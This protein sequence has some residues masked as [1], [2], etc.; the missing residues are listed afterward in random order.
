MSYRNASIPVL[1]GFDVVAYFSLGKWSHGV[2]G[3]PHLAVPFYVYND[4]RDQ[5]TY[6]Y[7]FWFASEINRDAFL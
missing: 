4:T 2:K 1:H 6:T 5:T 7:V 3:R